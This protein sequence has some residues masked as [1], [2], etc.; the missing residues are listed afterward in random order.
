MVSESKWALDYC[1]QELRRYKDVFDS[2]EI[3]ESELTIDVAGTWKEFYDFAAESRHHYDAYNNTDEFWLRPFGRIQEAITRLMA[4][5]LFSG[6]A[7][8]DDL[9]KEKEE[10]AIADSKVPLPASLFAKM[11]DVSVASVQRFEKFVQHYEIFSQPEIASDPES[12]VEWLV[13]TR[14]G[15][16]FWGDVNWEVVAKSILAERRPGMFRLW[17]KA[18][19]V[20]SI[21]F[22]KREG[23]DREN[24]T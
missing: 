13:A 22:L 17:I 7:S 14:T 23:E 3:H 2:F 6:V 24:G 21:C 5:A 4:H 9:S 18:G 16:G 8:L 10:Y 19:S 20:E 1:L 11:K 15:L 12:L